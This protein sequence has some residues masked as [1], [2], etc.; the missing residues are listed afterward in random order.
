MQ[1]IQKKH[2]NGFLAFYDT[3]AEK[4]VKGTCLKDESLAK[5]LE[6]GLNK[7]I[8]RREKTLVRFANRDDDDGI[9]ARTIMNH[10]GI[11]MDS[12]DVFSM[13][14]KRG[15]GRPPGVKNKSTLEKESNGETEEAK[16]KR[17]RGRPKGSKNKTSA[18]KAPAD[19]NAPKR[20]RG[21][22][23]GSKNKPKV[24]DPLEGYGRKPR[25]SKKARKTPNLDL[26]L[27]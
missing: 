2:P 19:P 15:R 3:K 5:D 11:K 25:K 17:G 27:V 8:N 24:V 9:F 4:F 16:P 7:F 22:P 21:R 20:G 12:I 10:K 18:M 13:P 1:I 6:I 26:S 14:K 23:K